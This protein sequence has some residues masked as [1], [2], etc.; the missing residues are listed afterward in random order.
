MGPRMNTRHG[1]KTFTLAQACT[2]LAAAARDKTPVQGWT[3][4][5]YRYPARFSPTFARTA[6]E[7]FSKRGDLVLDPYMGGGT[8]VVEALAAGR[9]VVGNDLNSLAAFIARVKTTPLSRDDAHAVLDWIDR[10]VPHLGFNVRIAEFRSFIDV[11]KTRNL[12]IAKARCLK[13]VLANGLATV[14]RLPSKRSRNFAQCAV[15]PRGPMGT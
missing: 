5:F 8:T 4:N 1:S 6:I 7:Q 3:H 9:S 12:S 2:L 11:Q 14:A 10:D 15:A 13:K